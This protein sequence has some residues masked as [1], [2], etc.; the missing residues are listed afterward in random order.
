MT[1]AV[2]GGSSL[3]VRC[4]DVTVTRAVAAALVP[5]VRAGDV[6]RLVGEMGAGKTA[7][8]QGLAAAAGVIDAVTSPT[9]ILMRPYPTALG[10]DLL[11]VDLYRLDTAAQV[12]NLGLDELVSDDAFAV[13]EWGERE[14]GQLGPDHLDVRITRP[15]NDDRRDLELCASGVTWAERWEAVA[16]DVVSAAGVDAV[17]A[18]DTAS[19]VDTAS[20]VGTAPG[21][22]GRP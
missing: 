5:H 13:I 22:G 6:V 10:L 20:K 9:F 19:D 17:P 18:G 4:A 3:M 21:Q 16:A 2:S 11:H 1:A 15:G 12:A 7:F 14:A 8:T